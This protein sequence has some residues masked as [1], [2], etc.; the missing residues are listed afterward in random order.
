MTEMRPTAVSPANA[1][2]EKPSPLRMVIDCDPGIDDAVALALAVGSPEVDLLAV[3]TVAGNA[4]L[5][6]TTD[7]ALRILAHLGRPEVPVAAGATRGLVRPGHHNRRSPH[8]M[9][10]LGGVPFNPSPSRVAADHAVER[11]AAICSDSDG[12]PLTIVALGPLTNIALFL[13]RYPELAPGIGDVVVMGGCI[14][15]GNIT[16][17]AEFNVWTDPDAALRVLT[18]V[19]LPVRVCGLQVTRLAT[20][21]DD[22]IAALATAPTPG[23][24]LARSIL[25]Y[26]DRWLGRRPL[27]D[28]L[29]LAW[30][31]DPKL[32]SGAPAAVEVDTSV[33]PER[34]LT[35][36]SFDF[37]SDSAA[38]VG[39]GPMAPPPPHPVEVGMEVDVEGFQ[40][41]L[42]D[43]VVNRLAGTAAPA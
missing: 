6:Q 41:L 34:G 26:E 27:H 33:G 23:A 38:G 13:A 29:A 8:G 12:A 21:D 40:R 3:T 10:G 24:L 22:A 9:D 42:A 39:P 19:G 2:P 1:A 17:V 18:E 5:D 20:V 7:N 37:D 16:P 11:L 43:R 4:P 15:R 30:A 31:I 35:V 14:G 32:V 36:F 28:A 25:A